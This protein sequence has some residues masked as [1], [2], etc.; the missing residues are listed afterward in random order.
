[1]LTN[2][3][4]NQG[5][6]VLAYIWT[7]VR[8]SRRNTVH[9][10]AAAGGYVKNYWS[11]SS[12]VSWTLPRSPMEASSFLARGTWVN[13]RGF[14]MQK[15]ALNFV[16]FWGP[17]QGFKETIANY[18]CSVVDWGTLLQAG[19]SRVRF[20]MRSLDLL[21]C[22]IFPAALWFGVDSAS[23]RNEYQESSWGVKGGRRVRLT[24]SPPSV[25]RLSRKYVSLWAFTACYKDSF[26][27]FFLIW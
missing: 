6:F 11:Q 27:F 24:T 9:A 8:D 19:R 26:A 5:R 12:F 25:S 18:S 14:Q 4:K 16:S 23:N 17:Y 10:E 15:R 2:L 20:P 22:I 7:L 3:S 1:M 21:I 13:L